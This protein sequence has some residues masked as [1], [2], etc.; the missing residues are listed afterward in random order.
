MSFSLIMKSLCVMS[1]RQKLT[2]VN[3]TPSLLFQVVSQ[4]QYYHR[5]YSSIQHEIHAVQ[6]KG[7]LFTGPLQAGEG[8]T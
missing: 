7:L 8:K 6:S 5:A 4:S 2:F 1:L 3:V